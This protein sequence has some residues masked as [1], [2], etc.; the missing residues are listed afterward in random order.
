[1]TKS[2]QNFVS[3]VTAWRKGVEETF[4]RNAEEFDQE[5]AKVLNEVEFLVKDN[6]A[7]QA[8]IDRLM[9]EYCPDEM[10]E[11]QIQNWGINQ[12]RA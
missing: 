4:T 7:K 3:A 2:N 10:T 9:L 5:M 1:M 11:E 6:E 12:R 8:K